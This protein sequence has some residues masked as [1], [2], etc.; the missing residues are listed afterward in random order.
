MSPA[1]SRRDSAMSIGEVLA[2]LLPDFPDV[3]VSKIRLWES[4]GLVEP[5]RTPSGYRKFT[6]DDV[7]RL[8]YAMAL[9]RDHYWP[10]RKIRAH[11][12]AVARGA[13]R[14][15]AGATGPRSVP[16]PDDDAPFL[17]PGAHVRLRADEVC[18]A[19]GLSREQLDELVG[20][21]LVTPGASGW[22]GDAAL[23]VATAAAE[24]SGYGIEARHLRA[25]RAAADR[26]VGLVEQVV[27]PLLRQRGGDGRARADD[28]AREI[29]AVALRLHAALVRAGLERSG[30]T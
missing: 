8:R 19:A 21:G 1:V 12:D 27:Q 29:S 4:E 26:E 9:Q 20:Y 15:V 5:S 2:A 3:S 22:F 6:S 14:P 16:S 30:L 24:L 13:E 23:Q 17:R 18:A 11:L 7:E 28:A 10:L 25:F